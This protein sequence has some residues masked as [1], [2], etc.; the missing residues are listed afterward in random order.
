MKDVLN[1]SIKPPDP[2]DYSGIFDSFFDDPNIVRDIGLKQL[3]QHPNIIN[4]N[5]KSYPGIRVSLTD[6]VGCEMVDKITKHLGR[7]PYGFEASYHL[8]SSVHS[9]GLVHKDVKRYAGVVYLNPEPP[10]DSGTLFFTLRDDMTE[11]DIDDTNEF[12]TKR[13]NEAS[14][15]LDINII[16]AF[17]KIKNKYNDLLFN[18]EKTIENVYNRMIIYKGGSIYHCPDTSFGDRIDNSRLAITFWFD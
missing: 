14:T 17:T 6:K 10:K 1:Y 12:I 7:K 15:T 2:P 11:E 9:N 13:F 5:G 3:K 16:E 4:D 8:S 18:I